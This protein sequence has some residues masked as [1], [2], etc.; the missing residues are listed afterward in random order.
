MSAL[1]QARGMHGD[2][3]GQQFLYMG[4]RGLGA[5]RRVT[6]AYGPAALDTLQRL[7]L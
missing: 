6:F 2:R 4:I 5:A 1:I 7:F 3:A